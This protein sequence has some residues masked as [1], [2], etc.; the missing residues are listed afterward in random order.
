MNSRKLV[1]ISEIEY[2]WGLVKSARKE[3]ANRELLR[4]DA[5]LHSADMALFE[6]LPEPPKEVER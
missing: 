3:L 1:S 2:I 4:C 5:L 6:L